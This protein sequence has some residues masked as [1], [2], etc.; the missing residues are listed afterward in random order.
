MAVE[1][2]ALFAKTTNKKSLS[3]WRFFFIFF[4]FHFHLSLEWR[5]IKYKISIRNK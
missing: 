2:A 4:F 1:L 3:N 5:I